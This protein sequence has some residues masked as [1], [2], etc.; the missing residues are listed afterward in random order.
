VEDDGTTTVD[1]TD[2]I[3]VT[4]VDGGSAIDVDHTTSQK[5]TD[6]LE[7]EYVQLDR[8]LDGPGSTGQIYVYQGTDQTGVTDGIDFADSFENNPGDWALVKDGN[9]V[10]VVDLVTSS[11][12]TGATGVAGAIS[13]NDVRGGAYVI[14]QDVPLNVTNG[15]VTLSADETA[16]ITTVVESELHADASAPKKKS[17]NK[18]SL[19]GSSSDPSSLAVNGIIATNV[20]LSEAK[21]ELLDSDVIDATDVDVTADNEA[22]VNAQTVNV[23]TATASKAKTKKGSGGNGSSADAIGITLAFNSVGWNSQ[24]ILFNT[25]DTLIGDPAI[26]DAFGANLGAGAT[27]TIKNTTIDAPGEVRAEADASGRIEALVTN[28]STSET[29]DKGLALGIVLSMNKVSSAANSSISYDVADGDIEITA[30]NGVAVIS[31]DVAEIKSDIE[32]ESEVEIVSPSGS[33]SSE[34]S[35]S[36]VAGLVSLNAVEG[37]AAS[38]VTNA[39]VIADAGDIVVSAEES[40]SILADIESEV[41]AIAVSF[42]K[43]KSL[44]VNGVIATNNVQRSADALVTDGDFNTV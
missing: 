23:S 1:A 11:A 7:G 8:D 18:G 39:D 2:G 24:N 13:T 34:K 9:I 42:G 3:T 27:A 4:A 36:A 22:T 43:N 33:S 31:K 15:N 17:S 12:G 26:A 35:A 21:A 25:V 37:G 20:V 32:I 40:A 41:T 29:K 16:V 30:D 10:S 6:L 44:A 5:V 14:I 28:K 38:T 19:G